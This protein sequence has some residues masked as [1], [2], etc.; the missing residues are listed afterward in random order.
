LDDS[1]AANLK[2]RHSDHADNSMTEYTV[3]LEDGR[4]F[5]FKGTEE[6]AIG[7]GLA[8]LRWE[9]PEDI[10]VFEPTIPL[11]SSNV[12]SWVHTINNAEFDKYVIEHDVG[13]RKGANHFAQKAEKK[14]TDDTIYYMDHTDW[15]I[16]DATLALSKPMLMGFLHGLALLKKLKAIAIYGNDGRIH[17]RIR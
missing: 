7:V 14:M 11:L 12:R 6:F 15:E 9:L 16:G 4:E 17:K 3:K 13:N 5:R 8:I 10:C 1:A 2:V